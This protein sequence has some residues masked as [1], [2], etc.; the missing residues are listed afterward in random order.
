VPHTA[1]NRPYDPS[2]VRGAAPWSGE[3][4]HMLQPQVPPARYLLILRSPTAP[5]LLHQHVGSLRAALQTGASQD[6]PA[7]SF[8]RPYETRAS[9]SSQLHAISDFLMLVCGNG[10]AYAGVRGD[11]RDGGR[12]GTG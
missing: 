12:V 1:C 2:Y 10:R 8:A 6:S 11:M 7:D 5:P 3:P 4:N 9:G